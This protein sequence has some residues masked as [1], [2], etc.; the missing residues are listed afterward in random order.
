MFSSLRSN[1]T[2]GQKLAAKPIAHLPGDPV[3]QLLAHLSTAKPPEL[4]VIHAA[5]LHQD[6][7]GNAVETAQRRSDPFQPS[8]NQRTG[9]DVQHENLSVAFG[10][11]ADR[12]EAVVERTAGEDLVPKPASQT[13]TLEVFLN[14]VLN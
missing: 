11:Q 14:L 9:G 6:E 4:V 3:L 5:V 7:D 13:E 2:V 8:A 10:A 12:Q 1:A